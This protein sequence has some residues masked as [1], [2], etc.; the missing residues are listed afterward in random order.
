MQ[1][2]I[3]Q[4][5]DRLDMTLP[6]IVSILRELKQRDKIIP[7]VKTSFHPQSKALVCEHNLRLMENPLDEEINATK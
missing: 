7:E 1:I 5:A 6:K 2:D 4:P 3:K